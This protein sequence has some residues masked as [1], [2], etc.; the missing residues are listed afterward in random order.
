[1][2]FDLL[3][4]LTKEQRDLDGQDLAWFS[5][6]TIAAIPHNLIDKNQILYGIRNTK[7]LERKKALAELI[8]PDK[9]PS[10]PSSVKP[11]EPQKAPSKATD[12]AS[13]KKQLEENGEL[14]KKLADESEAPID[15]GEVWKK[16]FGMV[17]QK[18]PTPVKEKREETKAWRIVIRC[19]NT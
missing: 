15:M 8:L 5:P 9:P 2:A 7:D 3:D 6:Q 17:G 1:M 18:P 12:T 19:F 11:K 10:Q 4:K 14:A 16:L 13:Q